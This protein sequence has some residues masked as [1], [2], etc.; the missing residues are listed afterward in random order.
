MDIYQPA[1]LVT[2]AG[3]RIGRAIAIGLAQEGWNVAVHYGR[4]GDEAQETVGLIKATGQL[5][6][7][8]Q[9][10]LANPQD[11]ERAFAQAC[12]ALPGLNMLVNCASV[13]EYD[14]PKSF[15]SEQL[16]AHWPVNVAAPAQLSR[17][18]FAW[19]ETKASEARGNIVNIV[20]QK[21]ANLN[22]DFFSYTMTKAA[23]L[24]ATQMMAMSFAPRLRVNAVSPGATM[25]SWKQSREG[26]Q[27]ANGNALLGRS[28][29]PEDLAQAVA[30]LGKALAVT[31]INMIVDGGQHLMPLDRDVMFLTKTF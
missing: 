23:L 9:A 22:P 26:Y 20:D 7:A 6:V 5:A 2:G 1:V 21:L 17:L 13:F 15:S 28:S 19:L 24:S 29:L 18:L 11:C 3:K 8:V 14:D 16:A 4:S 31:G 25:I 10:D 30:Y 27:Q 12:E